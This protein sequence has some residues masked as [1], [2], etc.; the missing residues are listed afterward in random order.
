MQFWLVLK[1]NYELTTN[2]GS[3]SN[4]AP[5]GIAAG[6][7]SL[8]LYHP[9]H[10]VKV[11]N[12]C[13]QWVS[14]LTLNALGNL[15]IASITYIYYFRLY[16]F[17]TM[18]EVLTVTDRYWQLLKVAD[19]CWPL[20]TVDECCWQML[21]VPESCWIAKTRNPDMLKVHESCWIVKSP[22]SRPESL[23]AC[24]CRLTTRKTSRGTNY[25]TLKMSRF[26]TTLCATV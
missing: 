26:Y 21:K 25:R 16:I 12:C 7:F 11:A 1:Q 20:L 14:N 4:A 3:S 9:R 23:H 6:N 13:S 10:D 5:V 15:N 22:Q 17:L 8:Y 2:Y 24:T 19:R 18:M